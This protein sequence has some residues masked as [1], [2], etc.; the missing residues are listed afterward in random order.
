MTN[1][2]PTIWS[3]LLQK[4]IWGKDRFQH[5]VE[6][7][8]ALQSLHH[9]T[10]QT[11]E[12]CRDH[13][14]RIKDW[15]DGI[16]FRPFHQMRSQQMEEQWEVVE[17]GARNTE[18]DLS[19]IQSKSR[20]LRSFLEQV[21]RALQGKAVSISDQVHLSAELKEFSDALV[22]L[23]RHLQ[24]VLAMQKSAEQLHIKTQELQEAVQQDQ[25][26]LS[27]LSLSI[28]SVREDL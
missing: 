28:E 13:N 23:D 2:A 14:R 25:N 20:S 18:E 24:S 27:D 21:E 1:Q 6:S 3:N 15:L 10:N 17:S 7:L 19:D 22:T 12:A 16:G 5:V 26:T 9:Q 8:K 11:L 4:A